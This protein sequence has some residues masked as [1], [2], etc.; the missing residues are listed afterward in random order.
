MSVTIKKLTPPQVAAVRNALPSCVT[1]GVVTTTTSQVAFNDGAVETFS[2]IT[3]E[4]VSALLTRKVGEASEPTATLLANVERKLRARPDL[5][6][7]S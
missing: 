4:K 5:V 7:E 3:V 6:V 1:A 2:H